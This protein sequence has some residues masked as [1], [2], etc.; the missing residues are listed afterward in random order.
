M[1]AVLLDE[2][3]HHE[4][5]E[6]IPGCLCT[7]SYWR[8]RFLPVV[9]KRDCSYVTHHES[10]PSGIAA[11]QK[12][13]QEN[14]FDVD[15]TTN[16]DMFTDSVLQNYSAVIF[17]STTGDVLNYKQEA[18]FERYIQ[19]GGGYVGVHAAADTVPAEV[20]VQTQPGLA[21]DP[22]DGRGHVT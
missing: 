10:I 5:L 13:G 19:A 20:G 15:T 4:S 18:A 14:N 8:S 1:P 7:E 11:I 17:L 6:S 3:A 21:G 12:L 9:I 16:P 22:A 2:D